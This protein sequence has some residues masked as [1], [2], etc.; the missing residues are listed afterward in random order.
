MEKYKQ[1]ISG[2]VECKERG[3]KELSIRIIMYNGIEFCSNEHAIN[4]LFKRVQ[5]LELSHE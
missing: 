1:S 2:C 4:W 5:K 3:I